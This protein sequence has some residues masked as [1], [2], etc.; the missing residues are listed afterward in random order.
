MEKLLKGFSAI[1][2]YPNIFKGVGTVGGVAGDF[3]RVNDENIALMN[4]VI[5]VAVM[6]FSTAVGNIMQNKV[7]PYRCGDFVA[8]GTAS[9]AA[10]PGIQ[11]GEA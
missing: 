7:I 2:A 10:N 8:G 4:P 5:L 11:V 1:E 9:S 3:S 6:V